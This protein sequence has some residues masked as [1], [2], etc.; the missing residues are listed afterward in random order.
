[1][2]HADPDPMRETARQIVTTL[3]DQLLQDARIGPLVALYFPDHI[4]QIEFED[5]SVLQHFD[6]RTARGFDYLRTLARIRKPQAALITL[7]VR[8]GRFE[9]DE[10]EAVADTTAIF[11]RLDPPLLTI[12][13]IAPYTR[14]GG[15]TTL[16][17]V[18]FTEMPDDENAAPCTLQD[19]HGRPC[20]RLSQIHQADA[21]LGSNSRKRRAAVADAPPPSASRLAPAYASMSQLTCSVICY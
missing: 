8:M 10:R 21:V 15:R 20:G 3:S 16:S 17:S 14:S 5:P 6:I 9:S 19:F 12:Q 11:V 2:N 18:H 13:A 1:M 7:H 4:E